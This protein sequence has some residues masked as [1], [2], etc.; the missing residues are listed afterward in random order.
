MTGPQATEHE[1]DTPD[2]AGKQSATHE[3][4]DTKPEAESES[5]LDPPKEPTPEPKRLRLTLKR[6][7]IWLSDPPWWVS[8]GLVALFIS[9]VVFALQLNAD[10]RRD[11]AN[12]VIEAALAAAT[13]ADTKRT[14][15]LQWVRERSANPVH[16]PKTG[17]PELRFV[18]LD[19][20]SQV[21]AGLT[22]DYA[23][24]R[25]AKLDNASFLD[26]TLTH[27]NFEGAHL[28]GA[29][30]IGVDLRETPLGNIADLTNASFDFAN[31]RGTDLV[32]V[33][34]TGA[35]FYDTDLSG[36]NLSGA[37]LSGTD[38]SGANLSGANLSGT[39]YFSGAN[40]SKANLNDIYYDANTKWP[41]GFRPPPSRPTP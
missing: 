39:D 18:H 9:L 40:L 10:N 17:V 25:G 3:V 15:N 29:Q 37:N 14:E 5:S 31:F 26:T 2:V 36:A 19:L 24:F 34:F 21:L 12:H 30:F 7:R 28:K 4:T 6:L 41:D 38:F 27:A 1:S 20:Q 32:G 11:T 33:N 23:D 13:A 35:H 8:N 16:D 22:L